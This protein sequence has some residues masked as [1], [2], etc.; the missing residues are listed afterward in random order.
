MI[1]YTKY[2]IQDTKYTRSKGHLVLSGHIRP[3]VTDLINSLHPTRSLDVTL[4]VIDI[5][6]VTDM[7]VS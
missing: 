1:Q 2:N 3:L 5:V 6:P 7:P 4:T